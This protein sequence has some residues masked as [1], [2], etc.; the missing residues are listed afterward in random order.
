MDRGSAPATHNRCAGIFL[1]LVFQTACGGGAS[2]PTFEAQ[3]AIPV[4]THPNALVAGD[5]DR[6][7]DID[8]VV[9][10]LVSNDYQV[11]ENQ[12]GR[13]VP[14]ARVPLDGGPLQAV[15]ADLDEDGT[16]DIAVSLPSS[17]RV[18]ILHGLGD[19]TFAEVGSV[20]LDVPNE[21]AILH[22]EHHLDL[23]V[24]RFDP[25]GLWILRGDGHGAFVADPPIAAPQGAGSIAVADFDGDGASDVAVACAKANMVA[26]YPGGA[27]PPA[28]V[29]TGDWP[30]ALVPVSLAGQTE[31]LGVDNLGGGAFLIGPGGLRPLP[32]GSGPIAAHAAD[33]DGDGVDE[34]GIT[35]KFENTFWILA[36]TAN[37]SYAVADI[38]PTGDGPTPFAFVDLDGDGRTDIVVANGFSNDL[39]VYFQR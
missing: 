36:L 1:S 16:L 20:P 3:P 13:L 37:G 6:D 33:I 25:G 30:V 29:A 27:G 38:L 26:V 12:A 4:P 7:G 14:H 19:L 5:F 10:G 23:A 18:A 28:T 34:I 39:V 8:I 35:N 24:T 32:A 9:F 17:G 15:A 11:F 2:F 21:L 22:G 31:I